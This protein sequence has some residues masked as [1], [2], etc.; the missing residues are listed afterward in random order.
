MQKVCMVLCLRYLNVA[1]SF[2]I[3]TGFVSLCVV[4]F[5]AGRQCFL[6]KLHP[7]PLFS[8]MSECF[9]AWYWVSSTASGFG[10]WLPPFHLF[11]HIIHFL[12][13]L[14]CRGELYWISPCSLVPLVQ[15][16]VHSVA[17]PPA[18]QRDDSPMDVDQPSPLEQ[19]QA[20]LGEVLWNNRCDVMA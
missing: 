19:D 6:L 2:V 10:L 8:P 1:S 14:L 7:N 20:A 11:S 5:L 16:E 15:S 17:E 4:W 13:L 3:L 9:D 18:A 12:S